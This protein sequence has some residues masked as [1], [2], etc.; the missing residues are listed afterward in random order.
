MNLVYYSG[1]LQKIAEEADKFLK[2]KEQAL[3]IFDRLVDPLPKSLEELQTRGE[4]LSSMLPK[5]YYFSFLPYSV[6]HR[7]FMYIDGTVAIKSLS[8]VVSV[9]SPA[10]NISNMF[11]FLNT[12]T[13]KG[14]GAIVLTEEENKDLQNFLR[15]KG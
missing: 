1:Y 13:G 9:S 2:D 8:T 12:Q 4:Y 5:T 6:L 7:T 3:K 11:S 15:M 14:V 10:I